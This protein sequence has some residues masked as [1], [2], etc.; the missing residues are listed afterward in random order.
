M[1]GDCPLVFGNVPFELFLDC[2]RCL[3]VRKAEPV[4]DAE[5]MGVDGYDGLV[6]NDRCDYVRGFAPYA[7]Q[8]HQGVDVRGYFT[9]EIGDEFL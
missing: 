3:S 6:V 7:W 4:R 9:A 5:D 2:E 1:V 8:R